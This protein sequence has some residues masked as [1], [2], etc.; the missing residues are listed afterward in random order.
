MKYPIYLPI[1]L[2]SCAFACLTNSSSA[3]DKKVY[4]L[5][6]VVKISGINWFNYMETGVKK[7]GRTPVTKLSNSVL[8]PPTPLSR[9]RS[10]KI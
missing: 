6:T 10:S 5:A 8:R 1:I 4:S 3:E 2:A 7:F 9:S